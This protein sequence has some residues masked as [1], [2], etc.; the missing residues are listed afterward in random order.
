M[1]NNFRE[2]YREPFEFLQNLRINHY[3]KENS[4]FY[5]KEGIEIFEFK[6]KNNKKVDFKILFWDKKSNNDTPRIDILI[7]PKCSQ[8]CSIF[9]REQ[10][11]IDSSF[12]IEIKNA[13]ETIVS[14]QFICN[15]KSIKNNIVKREF[16]Y[17]SY[18]EN[19]IQKVTSSNTY[20]FF[21]FPWNRK[22]ITAKEYVFEPWIESE[23]TV[24]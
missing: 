19:K 24:K 13:I 22:K 17:Y 3:I 10:Y 23:F 16:I 4:T 11:L 15:E 5:V 7:E 8:S 14:N 18:F 6:D 1:A 9:E 21:I 2:V 12:S 20:K